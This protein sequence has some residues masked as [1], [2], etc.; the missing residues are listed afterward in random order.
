MVF[1]SFD[2]DSYAT[3]TNATGW[4]WY[5]T[6]AT[7]S[8]YEEPRRVGHWTLPPLPAPSDDPPNFAAPKILPA[9]QSDKA[10]LHTLG[11]CGYW[12]NQV[13]RRLA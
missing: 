4:C 2:F 8:T 7:A 1:A 3:A 12:L 10:P 9:R 6:K 11:Q 13:G 5:D